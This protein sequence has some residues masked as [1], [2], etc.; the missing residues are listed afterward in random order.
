MILSLFIMAFGAG[1][2]RAEESSLERKIL[3]VKEAIRI[4]QLKYDTV[5]AA[6]LKQA[7]IDGFYNVFY[8]SDR[9]ANLVSLQ[10]EISRIMQVM[11]GKLRELEMQKLKE[12]LKNG[13]LQ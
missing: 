8:W 13:K 2:L 9:Y 5:E 4:Q 10:Y 6:I 1:T 3:V 7:E 11:R 12:D